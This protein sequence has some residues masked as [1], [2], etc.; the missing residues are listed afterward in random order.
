[1][2]YLKV[3]NNKR[4]LI[5]DNGEQFFWLG[6]TAWELLHSLSREEIIEYLDCR[7]KQGF[8]VIQ[9]VALA[10]CDGIRIP[11]FYGR[12][13]LL[14][15]NGDYSEVIP[16]TEGEYSY[17]DHVDYFVEQACKRN[18]YVALLPTWGDKYSMEW[19][20]GPQIFN[21]ENA[22]KY[23][24]WIGQRYKDAEN[25]IWVLG[26]DRNLQSEEH[27]AV[28][29]SLAR[30]I[31]ESGA[32]QL[33][34]FHPWGEQTSSKHFPNADWLDFHMI[35]SGHKERNYKN[36]KMVQHD[37]S[38]TPVK[39]TLDA[40]PR[41]EDHPVGFNAQNGYFDASDVRQAAYWAVFSGGCGVTYG[42]NCVWRMVRETSDYFIM[43]WQTALNRPAAGQ[44]HYLKDLIL[45][46]DMLSMKPS[47]NYL[48]KQYDGANYIPVLESGSK[49]YFYTPCGL[50]IE[51]NKNLL[52]KKTRWMN[53]RTG[54]YSDAVAKDNVFSP[55]TCGKGEDWVLIVEK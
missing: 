54:E 52:T 20:V 30:G 11:N 44:I 39:P 38:L 19:G 3:S 29:I 40:E 16:D 36:Y 12:Y 42:H 13:P 48:F 43:N 25:I 5:K 31:K 28:N 37:Y 24:L 9:T 21:R 17:W 41:Y 4:F 27:F 7:L 14:S 51:L 23:G 50:P 22:K 2:K 1:M 6:D 8:T 18:M 47:Q 49:I 45:S 15:N 53:P 34:T 10:E 46:D 35:Q 55:S 32:K 33:I 26:G